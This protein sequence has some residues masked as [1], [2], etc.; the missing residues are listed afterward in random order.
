MSKELSTENKSAL[1]RLVQENSCLY[2]V[3]HADWKNADKKRQLWKDIA[4]KLQLGAAWTILRDTFAKNKKRAAAKSGASAADAK[5]KWVHQQE[6]A[7]VEDYPDQRPT[8]VER[9]ESQVFA[10]YLASQVDAVES[11][12]KRAAVNLRNDLLQVVAQRRSALLAAIESQQQ[13]YPGFYRNAPT[14]SAYSV[15]ASYDGY[16]PNGEEGVINFTR[17]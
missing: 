11:L 7:F 16:T 2:D 14:T 12:D 15:E 3:T 8:G 5:I 1:I 13:L 10:D 6:M 17:L 4:D 9:T